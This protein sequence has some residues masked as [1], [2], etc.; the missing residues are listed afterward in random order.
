MKTPAIVLMVFISTSVFS[1]TLIPDDWDLNQPQDNA[2]YIYSMD[3]SAPKDTERDAV[4]EAEKTVM[5][6]LAQRIW[7]LVDS[8]YISYIQ[9]DGSEIREN[10]IERNYI[11]TRL[12]LQNVSRAYKIKMADGKYI[13]YCLV[14]ISRNDAARAAISAENE[15][16]SLYAYNYFSKRVPGLKPF[17]IMESLDG[18][19]DYHSW[20]IENCGILAVSGNN[21]TYSLGQFETFV[22][23]LF[24]DCISFSARYN[25]DPARFIYGAEKLDIISRILQRHGISFSWEHPRLTV[26]DSRKLGDLIRM[27][28]SM[29]Y[30]TGIETIHHNY[31]IKS[32]D[33]RGLLGR[34]LIRRIQNVSRKNAA[35]Y[36]LPARLNGI[37]ENDIVNFLQERSGL[38][39]RYVI[40]YFVE[41]F[42]ERGKPEFGAPAYLFA[43]G[44]VL[45]YDQILGSILLSE[46]IKNG[47]PISGGND[48]IMGY[49]LLT[50]RLFNAALIEALSNSMEAGN[51]Y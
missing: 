30:V 37:F 12:V 9:Q 28:P 26:N 40:V 7:T 15:L 36:T 35:L 45:V 16:S 44:K 4:A 3:R 22:R 48:L 17:N 21:Q 14:Y 8:R 24:P 20:V 11:S 49:E 34:E 33:E 23:I 10:A 13:A 46:T 31:N 2:E 32:F 18:F 27:D 38:P 47:I 39:C 41:T 50:R 43:E 42:V 51:V 29:V 6:Q 5:V 1:Q 25:G 19:N